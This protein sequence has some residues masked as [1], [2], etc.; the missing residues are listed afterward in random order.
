M[1]KEIERKFIVV[2]NL[3]RDRVISEAV[4]KQGYLCRQINAT[5]RVRVAGNEA[6]INIKSAT[7]GISREEY[8]YSIPVTDAEG[9]L[10]DVAEQPFIDKTRY[11][12]EQGGHVWDLDVFHGQ[13]RG[14]VLAEVEL[15]SEDEV[16]E[17]P[18]W[19]G[20]EV[21][22]DPRYYNAN[23]VKAPYSRW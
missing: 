5:V 3:W 13:N 10:Q 22:D 19:A 6:W 4:I 21:S 8:E 18:D 7:Q 20:Q 17:L 1:A 16:F 14:L 2:N 23:L 9:L 12:V 15:A 11:Q